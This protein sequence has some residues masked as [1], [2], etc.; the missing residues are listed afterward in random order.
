MTAQ[1]RRVEGQKPS[2]PSRH[3][4]RGRWPR[5]W[6]PARSRRG[7]QPE[8]APQPSSRGRPSPRPARVVHLR[9]RP[10]ARPVAMPPRPGA[11][12][13][14][15]G[16][17]P[18]WIADEPAGDTRA[19][20]ARLGVAR[21]PHGPGAEQ[22]TPPVRPGV[23]GDTRRGSATGPMSSSASRVR[24]GGRPRPAAP[25]G[26]ARPSRLSPQTTQRVRPR[27]RAP[28]PPHGPCLPA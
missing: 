3:A 12:L 10:A 5:R 27:S 8:P 4:A 21:S 28:A 22:V 1:A 23:H 26:G 15:R 13:A 7:R 19:P 2:R 18:T 17:S 11:R 20:R 9:E 6:P 25:L 16:A 14:R 24:E